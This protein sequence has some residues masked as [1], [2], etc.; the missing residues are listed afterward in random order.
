MQGVLPLAGARAA[1]TGWMRVARPAAR[2]QF[3]FVAIAF[4]CLAASFVGNDFSVLYVASQLELD[5]AAVYRFAA[6]WGGHE[7]SMLLWTLLLTLWMAA[8]SLFSRQLPRAIVARVL[9]V[10]GWIGVGFLLFMLFTSNPFARLH[11]ARRGRPR[12]QSA[13]AG[14]GMVM[15]PPMLYMGY[16][17]FSVAFAFA[18]AALLVGRAR[19]RVG[20]LVARHGRSPR[21]CFSR[22]ASCSAAAGRTT[23]SAGAAGGSGTRWKTPRSCRGSSAR[24]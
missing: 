3:V 8:V 24:R 10:M 11:A 7:G 19:C 6:V 21:G 2:A 20:A 23:S 12:P 13:A 5:A 1:S 22:S 9:G 14:P 15:H 17:G 4:G 16:V 18:I